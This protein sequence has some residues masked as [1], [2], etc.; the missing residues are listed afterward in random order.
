MLDVVCSIT[1]VTTAHFKIETT[2]VHS[3]YTVVCS[4]EHYINCS[5]VACGVRV[6]IYIQSTIIL[7]KVQN[8]NCVNCRIVACDRRVNLRTQH[9][10]INESTTK[11]RTL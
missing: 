1:I 9:H 10:N 3:K 5:F 4:K 2:G 8:A 7:M 11:V 6:T